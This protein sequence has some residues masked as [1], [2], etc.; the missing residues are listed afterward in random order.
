MPNADSDKS[1]RLDNSY[2]LIYIFFSF[3]V[4]EQS[5]ASILL[6]RLMLVEFYNCC[7]YDEARMEYSLIKILKCLLLAQPK[8]S[9]FLALS[10]N[11]QHLFEK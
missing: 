8:I 10:Q 6:K 5:K 11:D 2:C 3:S 1:R 7:K 4:T 9:M